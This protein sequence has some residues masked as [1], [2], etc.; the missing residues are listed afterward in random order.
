MDCPLCEHETKYKV[1]DW[2]E[3]FGASEYEYTCQCGYSLHFAYGSYTEIRKG[4]E[5]SYSWFDVDKQGFDIKNFVV[6]G[7]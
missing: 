6:P 5:Y 2:H 3:G 1:Y 4:V 7:S